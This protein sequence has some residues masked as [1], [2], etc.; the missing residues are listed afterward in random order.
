M[1][2]PFFAIPS[3]YLKTLIGK[4]GTAKPLKQ[5]IPTNAQ[6]SIL[7]DLGGRS[8]EG[9]AG[10]QLVWQYPFGVSGDYS[11]SLRNRL[12]ENLKKVFCLV[13]FY[14]AQ[15]NPIDVDVVVQPIKLSDKQVKVLPEQFPFWLCSYIRHSRHSGKATF[16]DRSLEVKVSLQR[17][18]QV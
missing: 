11:I 15:G 18:K 9:I 17:G 6:R 14:D 3:N 8:S 7:S 2:T 12:R 4:A 1:D 13:I 5:A 16:L 10:G